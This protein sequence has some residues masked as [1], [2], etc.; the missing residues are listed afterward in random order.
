MFSALFALTALSC[1][2]AFAN[3]EVNPNSQRITLEQHGTTTGGLSDTATF[4]VLVDG[5]VWFP[6]GSAPSVRS[7]GKKYVADGK[8]GPISLVPAGAPTTSSGSDALGAYTLLSWPWTLGPKGPDFET[9]VRLYASSSA[10]V[11]GQR[12][13]TALSGTASG[14]RDGLISAFPSFGVAA[15]PSDQRRG[16]LQYA[17]D[18][19]GSGA[20][21]GEWAKWADSGAKPGSGISGTAPLCIFD[22]DLTASVVLSPCRTPSSSS[23]STS[24]SSSSSFISSLATPPSPTL[25]PSPPPCLGSVSSFAPAPRSEP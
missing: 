20:Q 6:A 14:D 16:F 4:D 24:I 5:K 18:M 25:P 17:G 2:E 15:G 11:F 23:T 10:A 9:Y 1:A 21:L 3:P 19:V 22:E 7:M 13:V 12:F 8:S